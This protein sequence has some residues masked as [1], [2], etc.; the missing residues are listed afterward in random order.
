MI[1]PMKRLTL[2]AMKSDSKRLLKALQGIAAVHISHSE[3]ANPDD[4]EF[5]RL[6]EAKSRIERARSALQPFAQKAPFLKPKPNATLNELDQSLTGAIPV[7]EELER[8]EHDIAQ[9]KAEMEKRGALADA[10]EPW[11]ELD[12]PIEEIRSTRSVR[13][14]TGYIRKDSLDKLELPEAACMQAFGGGRDSALL[15][16][17]HDSALDDAYTALRALDF[18]DYQLPQLTGTPK[19]NIAR[20]KGE[21]DGLK[22]RLS[23]L[24]GALEGLGEHYGTI[25]MAADAV[26]IALEREG[27]CLELGAMDSV[28]MLEGWVRADHEDKVRETIEK[29]ASVY[30]LDTRD[31]LPE[32]NPPSALKNNKLVEPFEAIT[33]MYSPPS[34]RGIDA[35]PLTMPFYLLFFGMMLSDSGYGL[36]LFIGGT[37]LTRLKRPSGDFGKLVKVISM[38][39]L[40]TAICGL[41]IGTFFGMDWQQLLGPSSPLPLLF[42]PMD[43][44]MPMIFICCGL[45][46]LQMF[47]GIAAKMYMCFRNGDPAAAIFDNFSWI[48]IVLGIVGVI[49]AGDMPTVH[50]IAIVMAAVGGVML[51][52]FSNRSTKNPIKRMGTGFGQLYNITSWLGD[53]L[54]YVRIMALGLVTGAMGMVFNMIG[55]MLM[56]PSGKASFISIAVGFIAALILLSVMHLFSLFIN[57]LGTYVHCARL[58]YVEYYGK[59][60]EGDGIAFDPLGYNTKHVNVKG[61]DDR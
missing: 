46:L 38:S 44:V 53:T 29:S 6:G 13:Y 28:F 49:F 59:F 21:K 47:T 11:T 40:S 5:R 34:Y 23:S 43:Q 30:Y 16:A 54:S 17:V 35:A 55:G 58:Q 18:I 9:I 22:D 48:L 24:N 12:A 14:I 32:E 4:G 27:K 33:N 15:I 1:V 8:I 50:T 20:L 52:F 57:T 42:N 56:D 39:G 45:G 51:L 25:E 19:E 61:T 10:L 3:C 26:A 31:P 36:L 37:L 41:F 7:L 60:Y 2:A